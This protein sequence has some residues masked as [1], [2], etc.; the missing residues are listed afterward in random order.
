[1][2]IVQFILTDSSTNLFEHTF[3][4][5]AKNFEELFNFNFVSKS[6]ILASAMTL[7]TLTIALTDPIKNNC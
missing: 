2:L 4:I 5:V 6:L 7:K 3:R 1:M